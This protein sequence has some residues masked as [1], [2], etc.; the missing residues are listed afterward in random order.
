MTEDTRD[1][2]TGAW[3]RVDEAVASEY[4]GEVLVEGV[5]EV[6]TCGG[7]VP[8]GEAGERGHGRFLWAGCDTGRAVRRRR[9]FALRRD[10]C[11]ESG[12]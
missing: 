3:G 11:H 1:G 10:P 8:E 7:I 6:G 12:R 9:Y 4:G 5:E 2:G